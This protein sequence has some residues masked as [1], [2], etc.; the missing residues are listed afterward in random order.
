MDLSIFKV[1]GWDNLQ[2]SNQEMLEEFIDENY[3]WLFVGRNSKQ[4]F[5]F[6]DT[7]PGETLC[8]FRSTLEEIDVTS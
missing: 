2:P 8:E 1:G 5:I 6:C 7:I 4:R 3:L